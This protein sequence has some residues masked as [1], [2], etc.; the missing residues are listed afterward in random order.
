[1]RQTAQE[2]LAPIVVDDRFRDDRAEPGHALAEPCRHPAVVKRQIGAARPSSHSGLRRTNGERRRITGRPVR[3]A[4]R[5]R[6]PPLPLLRERVGVRVAGEGKN[7]HR[8]EKNR[9]IVREE[10]RPSPPNQA[11][12]PPSTDQSSTTGWPAGSCSRPIV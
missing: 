8:L 9:T 1:M 11:C 3:I 10:P 5:G 7:V 4:R 2:L 6:N 12:P